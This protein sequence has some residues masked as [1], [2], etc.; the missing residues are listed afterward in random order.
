MTSGTNQVT[1]FSCAASGVTT[2]F[3]TGLYIGDPGFAAI[4]GNPEPTFTQLMVGFYGA[5]RGIQEHCGNLLQHSPL[6]SVLRQVSLI[7]V[8]DYYLNSTQKR[9]WYGLK[10]A[11]LHYLMIPRKH[12][13]HWFRNSFSENGLYDGVYYVLL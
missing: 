10:E 12:E 6:F 4:T 5:M 7:V 3:W 2:L 1:S 11:I 13:H 8:I 9:Y